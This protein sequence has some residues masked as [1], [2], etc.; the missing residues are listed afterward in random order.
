MLQSQLSKV[1]WAG[2]WSV[3]SRVFSISSCLWSELCHLKTAMELYQTLM[4]HKG[5]EGLIGIMTVITTL[6]LLGFVL[7]P[8]VLYLFC[9]SN[10]TSSRHS[11][12]LSL[13]E[14][15][16]GSFL[17]NVGAL[18][19]AI[20]TAWIDSMLSSNL[21]NLGPNASLTVSV[22]VPLKEVNLFMLLSEG[23]KHFYHLVWVLTG[24]GSRILQLGYVVRSLNVLKINNKFKSHIYKNIW[25]N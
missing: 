18:F 11:L 22:I 21:M 7:T 6:N 25:N 5:T 1:C 12:K 20:R 10:Y 17:D 2:C 3:L 19:L 24:K 8:L 4:D 13:L 14:T 15:D 9:R 23:F 16:D